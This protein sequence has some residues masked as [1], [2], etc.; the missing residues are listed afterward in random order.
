[1]GGVL[2]PVVSTLFDAVVGLIAGALVLL[3]V[4]GAMK[5]FKRKA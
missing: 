5:I 2:K 1:V 3:V 4:T